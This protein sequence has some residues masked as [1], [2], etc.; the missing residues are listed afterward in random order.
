MTTTNS[1][2]RDLLDILYGYMPLKK[3]DVM[4]TLLSTHNYHV[5]CGNFEI[6]G[7]YGEGFVNRHRVYALRTLRDILAVTIIDDVAHVIADRQFWMNKP[8]A[9]HVSSEVTPKECILEFIEVLEA[10][11]VVFECPD[12]RLAIDALKAKAEQL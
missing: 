12:S 2:T 4:H 6:N 9:G 8:T 1:K 11:V 10:E 5:S 7:C 3:I